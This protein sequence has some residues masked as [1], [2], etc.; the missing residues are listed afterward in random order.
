M[1][2]RSK[3]VARWLADARTGS[4]DALGQALEACRP[5]LLKIARR[6]LDHGLKAKAGASD[7]IQEA[8]LEAQRDFAAFHGET[9]KE[10]LAWLRQLLLHNLANFARSFRTAKRQIDSETPLHQKGLTEPGLAAPELPPMEQA[11][12]NEQAELIH[13]ALRRLPR[14]YRVVL[15]LRY[16]EE[17]SFKEIG[18][19]CRRSE[20][21]VRKLFARTIERIQQELEELEEPL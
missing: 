10:W 9:E 6:H 17:R 19:R 15:V 20:N 16:Q 14:D 1:T 3:D 4:S 2:Q 7:L 11:I 12:V 13:A 8:Y 21:A 18:R 5:Y